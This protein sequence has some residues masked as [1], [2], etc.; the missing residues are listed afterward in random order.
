MSTGAIARRTLAVDGLQTSYLEAGPNEGEPVVLLH[1][2]EFGASAGLAWERIIPLLAARHRVLAPDQLGYGHTAKV[3]DFTDGRALRT[4]HVARFCELLGIG[5]ACFAGNSM[6][7]LNL[8]ADATSG[9]PLLPASRIALLCGGGEIQDNEH[10]AA[11]RDYDGSLAAMRRVVTALFAGPAYADDEGY[12]RR[13]HASSLLPGAWEAVAAARFR[14]PGTAGDP[15]ADPPAASSAD[16]SNK[17]PA[18]DLIPSRPYHRITVPLLA[19]EGGS[20]KLLPPGWAKQLAAQVPDG[21]AAIVGDAGHCPQIERPE[22][23]ARLLLDF[24][25]ADVH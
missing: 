23:T 3:H 13:R 9:R 10:M 24:Y 1:G 15:P 7:A 22:E 6:G 19:V 5:S 20:D 11:L 16:N 18:A 17:P 2:G 25:A 8:L 12:V 4:R 21:T 14:R